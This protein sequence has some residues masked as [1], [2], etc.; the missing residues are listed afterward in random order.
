MT[1]E[2]QITLSNNVNKLNDFFKSED[3]KMSIAIF[4]EEFTK[5]VKK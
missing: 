5:F 4:A 2:Q 1:T 3:G